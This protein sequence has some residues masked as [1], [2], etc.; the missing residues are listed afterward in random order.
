MHVVAISR[1]FAALGVAAWASGMPLALGQSPA[2]Y[3]V[4]VSAQVQTSPA[5]VTL[6][7]PAN[8]ANVS[9]QVYRKLRDEPGWASPTALGLNATSYVD[10]N[11]VLGGAYEYKVEMYNEIGFYVGE[12]EIYVGIEAPLQ[13]FRGKVILIVDDTMTADLAS[14][15]TRLQQD[16]VGDGWT[17]LRHNVPRMTVNPAD[18]S[19]SVWA[20]RLN[21]L[22]SVK[23]LITSDYGA[24]PANVKAVFLVGRVPVPYSGDI[25]PDFHSDHR[26]AW[27]ADGYYGDMDGAWGDTTVN[28]TTASDPRNRN[29]PGDGKFDRVAWPLN[30]LELQVGR[31]DLSNLSSF[32]LSEL[33]LLRRYLDKNHQFRHKTTSVESQGLIDDGLGVFGGEAPA[34]SAWRDFAAF[35]GAAN[36]VSGDWLTVPMSETY[37]WAFGC[38]GGTF[39]SCSGVATTAQLAASDPRIVFAM[40]FG[41]YFGDW[42]SANNLMRAALATP[43]Y[44]LSCVW[45]AR[46]QWHFH[47]MGLGETIGFSTR[48]SQNN[49]GIAYQSGGYGQGVHIALMGDPTLRMHPVGPASALSA[50]ANGSGGVDLSWTASTDTVLGYHVYRAGAAGGPYTR[51]NGTLI[52]GT[53]YTDSSPGSDVHYMVRAVKL[54]VSGSGSYYNASQGIFATVSSLPTPAAA[55]TSSANPAL[56]GQSV[57]FTATL[58]AVPPAVGVPTGTVQFRIDD[59]NAGGPVALSGGVANYVTSTLTHGTHAVSADYSGDASFAPASADLA[60]DQVINTPPVAGADTVER[61]ALSGRKVLV[62]ALLSNDTDADSDPL[63]FVDVSATS[64][65]GAALTRSGDWIF[66]TPLPGFTNPDTFTYTFTDPFG[67]AVVSTVSVNIRVDNGP[68]PN[69]TITDLGNGSYQVRGDGIPERAYRIQFTDSMSPPNWQTLATVPADPFGV[70]VYVDPG[71]SAT[72]FYRSVWP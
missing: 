63:S 17:V 23:A 20:A 29:V 43:S 42:D 27:P 45:G 32:A 8:S 22:T 72:R 9:Y 13:E 12:G 7:W 66:Y 65:H 40:L 30:G 1:T 4:R 16:L 10:S 62:S 68:S 31:V 24:D 33:E 3:A 67:P 59:A 52:N 49:N 71:G 70:F 44:T 69:L 15:L 37:L 50:F 56:P 14:E 53:S 5:K 18:T 34:Q 25:F 61:D 58:S 39:T 38:G 48:L 35:F 19:S 60:P 36:T 11:V 51:V 46:P 55:L 28:R 47:H 57:T 6:S 54:E 64:T 21:E 26:G 2:D 41:S